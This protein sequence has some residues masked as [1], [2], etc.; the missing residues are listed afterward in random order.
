[1]HN[2]HNIHNKHIYIDTYMHIYIHTYILT[3]VN[4]IHICMRLL[5]VSSVCLVCE[6][7]AHDCMYTITH[8][9]S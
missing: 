5:H 7:V 1:M 3:C 2:M 6:S 8:I 4:G 9:D